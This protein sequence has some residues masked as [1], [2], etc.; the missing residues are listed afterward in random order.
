[1]LTY[2]IDNKEWLFS[3]A[4]VFIAGLVVSVISKRKTSDKTI[5]Q[6]K[7]H[8]SNDAEVTDT[9]VKKQDLTE[10]AKVAARF[11]EVLELMNEGRAYSKFTIQ[12][13]AQLMKLHRISELENIFTGKV[14]PTF[15]F[16]ADFSEMLGVNKDWLIEGKNNPF[17][18]ELTSHNDP[19]DYLSTILN[20]EPEGIYFIRENT[21]TSAAFILLKVSKWKYIVIDRTW[22]ISDEVGAGGQSQLVSFF[23]FIKELRD[24]RKLHTKCWGLTLNRNEFSALLSGKAFPGKHI[25][26]SFSEDPWWD[27]L[28]DINHK[29]PISENYE[30]WHGKS[31]IK[32]QELIKWK[33][34]DR[35]AS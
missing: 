23:L 6:N 7:T 34:A 28:T 31:F 26:V 32:A 9:G 5:I 22:H 1:M 13:L 4:G 19:M 33:L 21:D 15:D 35:K 18:N 30:Q 24:V 8:F 12:Q 10:V 29:Y 27:D 17:S 20:F 3:G 2:I 14:E 11:K 16:I 25:D